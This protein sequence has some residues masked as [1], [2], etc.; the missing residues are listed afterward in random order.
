MMRT[1]PRLPRITADLTPLRAS[2][3]LR[4]LVLGNF[5]SGMG[6]QAA[7][8]ALPYQVYV[9]THSALKTGLLG[10]AELGPL[11]LMAL[12]GGALADRVDRRRLLLLDQIALVLIACALCALALAGSPPL[13]ALY[14]LAGLL[15]GFGAI[16]NVTRSA[17]VPNLVEPERLHAA[18][19]VN[20]GL[21]QLTMVIGP[22]L[23]GLLIGVAGIAAAYG[24]DAV[25]CFA[26]VFALLGMAPQLPHRSDAERPSI[27]RSI[28]DGLSFVRRSQALMGSFAIDLVAMTF[29]MPRALFP[30][31]AVGVYGAGAGGTGLLFAAV[32]AGATVAALTTR[33]LDR[34]HRLGR[35][36]IGAVLVWG[37]AIALAGSANGLWFAAA[38]LAVAGAADSVSAVCR[39]IINQTVTP[40]A[41]RGRMSSV[42]S[43]VVTS[44]PRL[45]D[46]ESGAVASLTSARFSMA[47]G[48]LACLAGTAAV[49]AAFPA[50]ASYDRR[51]P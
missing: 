20:F 36:V 33:W 11:V 5:V 15:A 48:G 46:I 40:D 2:R 27:R 30:V 7:L 8:V 17:I 49:V 13:G 28:G 21:Y 41:M 6:T 10:A 35:I 32:S 25:S 3:E 18:L 39:A 9:Q 22:A 47:S 26:M 4:L 38:L 44:G 14:V 19:A 16:Q 45:G 24:V 1:M 51:S 23:G 50:L 37:L 29:G 12:V 34:V 31:L 43:L 42:F